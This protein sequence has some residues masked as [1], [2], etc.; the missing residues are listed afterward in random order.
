MTLDLYN[1]FMPYLYHYHES[2][3][4]SSSHKVKGFLGFSV[5]HSYGQGKYEHYAWYDLI[6]DSGRTRSFSRLEVFRTFKPS[7]RVVFYQKG[8]LRE[9]EDMAEI[10]LLHRENLYQRMVT[11]N[12]PVGFVDDYVLPLPDDKPMLFAH[13]SHGT[14]YT[15]ALVV[16]ASYSPSI[17]AVFPKQHANLFIDAVDGMLG[18]LYERGNGT[19]VEFRS[20]N[21]YKLMYGI[22]HVGKSWL[23]AKDFDDLM[24]SVNRLMGHKLTVRTPEKFYALLATKALEVSY[25]HT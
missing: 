19:R 23:D 11:F 14:V 4:Y 1:L 2:G 20:T 12:E 6:S 21:P 7:S 13:N 8:F 24:V 25:A 9:A 16:K 18:L 5:E 10:K 22:T 15:A 17:R 3:V